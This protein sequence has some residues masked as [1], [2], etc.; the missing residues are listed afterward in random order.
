MQL[1]QTQCENTR[2]SNDLHF[3]SCRR[4]YQRHT[5]STYEC[6]WEQKSDCAIG[7]KNEVRTNFHNTHL[8]SRSHSR[9]F[10]SSIHILDHELIRNI[11]NTLEFCERVSENFHLKRETI[12]NN[13]RWYR[14]L[15][16]W[17]KIY[18]RSFFG[19]VS[20]LLTDISQT[21][22][23]S[24]VSFSILSSTNKPFHR[25]YL[26]VHDEF[27][28]KLRPSSLLDPP[29]ILSVSIFFFALIPCLFNLFSSS[30]ILGRNPIRKNDFV[31]NQQSKKTMTQ[32]IHRSV[33]CCTWRK[34]N[35]SSLFFKRIE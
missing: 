8:L 26:R 35:Y 28:F 27:S 33:V 5:Y 23:Q 6:A 2:K 21:L 29:I 15:D 19:A 18:C 34:H 4:T 32:S 24:F 14:R 17:F 25:I 9:F 20:A 31:N 7:T 30:F 12:A 3:T 22:E 13:I 16:R 11:L 10:L 1:S